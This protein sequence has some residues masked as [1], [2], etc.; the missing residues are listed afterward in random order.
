[1]MH[2]S[3]LSFRRVGPMI[4]VL[5][6]SGGTGCAMFGAADPARTS[7]TDFYNRYLPIVR[8]V[9]HPDSVV[10]GGDVS[11]REMRARW[12]V[13]HSRRFGGRE[14][15]SSGFST[16]ATLWSRELS[17]RAAERELGL[18]DLSADVRDRA[19][20]QQMDRYAEVLTFD[21]H[22]FVPA[23]RGYSSTDTDLR[24][25][26]VNII[27]QDDRQNQYRPIEVV[28]GMPEHHQMMTTQPP[29]YYRPNQ[30][31]FYRAPEGTDILAGVESLRLIIRTAGPSADEVWFSWQFSPSD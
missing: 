18:G 6:L 26:G 22:M 30:I 3:V 14:F 1:M 4:V 23:V 10:T 27:L 28:A 21:I 25:A 16:F 11:F 5:A 9:H 20:S 17:V 2:S 12:S 31:I 7:A 19:I 24:T 13:N 8:Q 15:A 29:V